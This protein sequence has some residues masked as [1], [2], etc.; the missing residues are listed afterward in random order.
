MAREGDRAPYKEVR[1]V[2]RNC[3]I[4]AEVLVD[5]TRVKAILDSGAEVSLIRDEL[6]SQSVVRPSHVRLIDAQGSRIRVLGELDVRLGIG[7]K[8]LEHTLV[9]ADIKTDLLL[10]LDF[11]TKFGVRIDFGARTLSMGGEV[12]PVV[13]RS[14]G[15]EERMCLAT[16]AAEISVD[17]LES[18]REQRERT[19]DPQPCSNTDIIADS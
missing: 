5:S 14:I 19:H 4:S 3:D 13:K 17:G 12:I 2:Q 1:I 10:G 8:V 7:H 15:Q 16:F 11:L 6:V 9:V 18:L